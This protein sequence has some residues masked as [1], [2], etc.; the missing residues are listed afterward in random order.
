MC[1]KSK[2]TKRDVFIASLYIVAYM[3]TLKYSILSLNG[4]LAIMA[5]LLFAV[6]V[7][8][9]YLIDRETKRGERETARKKELLHNALAEINRG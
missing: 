5:S 7:Y 9:C 6:V 8:S 2:A 3:A 1:L 4:T